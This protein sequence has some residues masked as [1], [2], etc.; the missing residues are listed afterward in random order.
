MEDASV[1]V[2]VSASISPCSVCMYTRTCKS[3][4]CG[5]RLDEQIER[6]D[7]APDF[8]SIYTTVVK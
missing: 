4:R 2:S 1:S 8:P 6:S 7:S 5:G 3:V